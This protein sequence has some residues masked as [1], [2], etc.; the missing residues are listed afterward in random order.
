MSAS[1]FSY[2]STENELILIS[3]VLYA[4]YKGGGYQ[5]SKALKN[6]LTQNDTVY[7]RAHPPQEKSYH[8]YINTKTKVTLNKRN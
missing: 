2:F 7:L 5:P 4:C 1:C 6:I 3:R 8:M